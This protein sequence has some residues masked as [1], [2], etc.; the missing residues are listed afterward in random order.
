MDKFQGNIFRVYRKFVAQKILKKFPDPDCC[1]RVVQRLK[2]KVRR[3]NNRR[4]LGEHF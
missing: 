4:K 2:V 1:N 3:A